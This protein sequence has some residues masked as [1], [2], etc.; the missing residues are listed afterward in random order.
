MLKKPYYEFARQCGATHIVAHLSA[1]GMDDSGNRNDN[2]PIGALEGWGKTRQYGIWSFDELFRLKKEVQE[3][4][5]KLEAIENFDPAQ[6]YDVLLGGPKRDEQLERLCELIKNLGKA[7]IPILGYNFSLAGVTGRIARRTRGNALTTGMD[8]ENEIIDA[9]IPKGMIWNMRYAE[10]RY[11]GNIEEVSKDELWR[12]LEYFLKAVVPVAEAA[13]VM[14]AAHPD[15][16]PLEY[17]RRQPRLVNRTILYQRLLDIYP[18]AANRIELCVGSLAEMPDD[19]LY[20]MIGKYIG[21]GKVAYVHLRNVVGKVPRYTE[22]FIDDG[23]VDIA[24]VL[25]VLH[26]TG[27]RG[28]IIPDHAPQMACAAPWHSGMAFSMGYL[29]AKME[30]YLEDSNERME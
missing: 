11:D 2:Q 13:D 22:T 24:R 3:C 14:L 4:D 8:G 15:D 17:V 26:E 27:F 10:E 7:G 21:M 16:P 28:V 9:P 5:L 18:S 19:D 29:K 6:W 1:Y 25:R 30:Q 23:D 12:R 20:E